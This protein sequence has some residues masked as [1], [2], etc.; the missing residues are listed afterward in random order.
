MTRAISVLTLA[1]L[2][3]SC[4][5]AVTPQCASGSVLDHANT[6]CALG[7]VTVT[8]GD[9]NAVYNPATDCAV[10]GSGPVCPQQSE[11]RLNQDPGP[12]TLLMTSQPNR[13]TLSCPGNCNM[14]VA[15]HY[16]VTGAT[17]AGPR[18][19]AVGGSGPFEVFGMQWVAGSTG[20]ARCNPS[21]CGGGA[22][23]PACQIAAPYCTVLGSGANYTAG[24]DVPTTATFG[25]SCGKGGC[26]TQ[27][28]TLGLHHH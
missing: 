9:A 4:Q 25:V 7:A 12:G 11:L 15:I 5:R 2:L 21:G 17:Q 13:F 22:S 16:T 14:S 28:N 20:S 23:D 27:V 10:K 8:F 19:N 24:G 6:S 18:L 26:S 1:A 3:S